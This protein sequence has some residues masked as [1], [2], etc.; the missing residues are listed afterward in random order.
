MFY[1]QMWRFY[2]I[3]FFLA[4]SSSL[5]V[6][7]ASIGDADP[8]YRSCLT[9]CETTG[10]VGSLCFPHC[11]FSSN[12]ASVDGPWYMQEPLYIKGKQLYCQSDCRYHCMLSRENDRAASGHGP[13]K[14]HG[15]WPFKRVFGVQEPASV[16]FSVLNLVMHFHGWLSFFILLHYKL[17]MKSDKK[18]HYDYAGLWYLYGLL[19]L[20]SWFWSAVFHSW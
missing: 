3:S 20:N 7:H 8:S 11:N 19:A 12:G 1:E 6:L 10:C 18:P 9:D 16:A 5:G 13:V 2:W 4:F 17:P 14:Y 15:K